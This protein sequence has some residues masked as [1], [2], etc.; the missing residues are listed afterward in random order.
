[1]LKQSCN[2]K[3]NPGHN[4]LELWNVLVQVWFATSKTKLDILY[5]KDLV[6]GLS[7]ELPSGIILLYFFTLFQ[8]F[9][10]GLS[11]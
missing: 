8:I 2:Q 11:E 7:L 9:Y 6:P 5:L 4:I 10:W 3:F 1:M